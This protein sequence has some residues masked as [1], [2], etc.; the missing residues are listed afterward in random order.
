[1]KRKTLTK[2]LKRVKNSARRKEKMSST[3]V[4]G[5]GSLMNKESLQSTLPGKKIYGWAVL[6]D[7]RRKFNKPGLDHKYLNLVPADGNVQQTEGVLIEVT[8]EELAIL[9]KREGGYKIV[10]VTKQIV[11]LPKDAVVVAF[12]A[13]AFESLPIRKSYLEKVLASLPPEKRGQW[14]AETDLNNSDIDGNA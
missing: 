6:R 8:P 3:F 12:I 10:D 4:F 11:D 13:P 2:K 14:L 7:W 9:K 5:Y 1:M